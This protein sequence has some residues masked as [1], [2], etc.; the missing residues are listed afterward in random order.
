MRPALLA[1]LGR[2]VKNWPKFWTF[3]PPTALFMAKKMY[4]SKL[5]LLS[6]CLTFG[7]NVS[8]LCEQVPARKM[9][10]CS[11]FF[12]KTGNRNTAQRV[13]DGISSAVGLGS[14]PFSQTHILFQL[15]DTFGFTL[16]SLEPRSSFRQLAGLLH[17]RGRCHSLL[18][19][20]VVDQVENLLPKSAM[21][22]ISRVNNFS[23]GPLLVPEIPPPA[24]KSENGKNPFF[25][26]V[27]LPAGA[28]CH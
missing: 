8:E 19:P 3:G 27:L 6:W 7:F 20:A 26:Q 21:P 12:A 25:R 5:K 14:N 23:V 11:R 9:T 13:G 2:K 28:C 22:Y 10:R 1:Q 4:P 16:F 24:A 18:G 17:K 15:Q